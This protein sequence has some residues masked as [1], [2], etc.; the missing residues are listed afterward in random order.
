MFLNSWR[1]RLGAM[2]AG[3]VL[4]V[5]WMVWG[6]SML[7]GSEPRVLIEFGADP[8]Q[9]AGLDVEI[10]GQVAGKLEQIGQATRTAFKVS[11]GA[12]TVR[13]LHPEFGCR[14]AEVTADTPGMSTMLLLDHDEMPGPDSRPMLTLHP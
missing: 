10:D 6:G 9:F 11:P 5:T 2:G 8:D 3:I 1:I 7:P 12:H 14:P 13:V 4:M